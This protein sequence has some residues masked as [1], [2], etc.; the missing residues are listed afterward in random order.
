M[1][2]DA[3][4]A[5]QLIAQ[6]AVSGFAVVDNVLDQEQIGQLRDQILRL[7]QTDP[8]VAHK[9]ATPGRELLAHLELLPNKGEIF[10]T[11]FLHP[12]VH[13]VV[14]HF[15]G[16][17]FIANDLYSIGLLPGY[18][19]R[20][21]HV[22]EPVTVPGRTLAINV[23]YPLVDFDESNGGTRFLPGS[24]LYSDRISAPMLQAATTADGSLAGVESPVVR[25]GSALLIMGGVYHAPG[26]NCSGQL[27]PALA[28]LFSVPWLKPYVDL[29]R[30][31]DPAV[32]GRASRLALRLFGF[33]SV[34]PVGE[35]W[36]WDEV[37]GGQPLEWARTNDAPDG[38]GAFDIDAALRHGPSGATL[39]GR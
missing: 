31:L 25:A 26:S 3:R 35:R 27:R 12:L 28:S 15:L 29:P 17:D 19:G 24:H 8:G 34:C 13:E 1:D 37:H 33:G 20:G 39:A 32:L 23:L 16:Q 5:E 18:P 30:S 9:Q 11:Y 36:A 6:L 7:Y 21:Y 14:G 22:D 38:L 4:P 2:D 10:E